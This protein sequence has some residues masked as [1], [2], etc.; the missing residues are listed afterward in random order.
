MADLRSEQAIQADSLVELSALPDTMVWRNNTGQAWQGTEERHRVGSLVRVT[1][2]MVI[3]RKA[4]R[5][6]FGLTGSAD[7]LGT[8]KRE[9]I[10]WNCMAPTIAG[11]PIAVEIKAALG[12]QSVQ[13][14]AFEMSWKR[15]GGLYVLARTPEQSVTGVTHA[16]MDLTESPG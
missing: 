14:K 15:A 16:K 11:L 2:D 12:R 8:R 13:Q 10:C 4:R 6:K 3:L 5:V 1:D 9:I 7:I